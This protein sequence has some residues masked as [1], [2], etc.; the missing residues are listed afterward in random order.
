MPPQRPAGN[1][2]CAQCRATRTA[3][4]RPKGAKGDNITLTGG[5]GTSAAYLVAKLKRDAPEFAERYAVGEFRS[6][7]AGKRQVGRG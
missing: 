4:R 5:R 3:W 1:D 7:R 2:S 6:A